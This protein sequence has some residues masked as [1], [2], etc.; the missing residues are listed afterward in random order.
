MTR[1]FW[2]PLITA[3]LFSLSSVIGSYIRKK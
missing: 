2:L 1:S 3:A